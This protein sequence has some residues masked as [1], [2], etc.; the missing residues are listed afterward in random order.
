MEFDRK[1]FLYFLW[2]PPCKKRACV[3]SDTV[4]NE[5]LLKQPFYTTLSNSVQWEC[6]LTV[7]MYSCA[8][9]LC[10]RFL[11]LLWSSFATEV[12]WNIDPVYLHCF[13]CTISYNHTSHHINP[14][15]W[16]L[17]HNIHKITELLNLKK[18][19]QQQNICTSREWNK[20]QNVA[21]IIFEFFSLIFSKR[22]IGSHLRTQ[23]NV[24]TQFGRYSDEFI[25]DD[26]NTF[27]NFS[28][29]NHLY[30]Y[31]Y[32]FIYL[33]KVYKI[34]EKSFALKFRLLTATISSHQ[35]RSSPRF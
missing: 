9:T 3:R 4:Q 19:Q 2:F 28:A 14:R 1:I 30:L 8:C 27:R 35:L 25:L 23:H 20:F 31:P 15:N 33:Q 6:Y 17:W 16:S 18:Q 34:F 24:L 5:K 12:L 11:Q 32:L 26:Y 22:L 13:S 21:R 10:W 29:F 7:A